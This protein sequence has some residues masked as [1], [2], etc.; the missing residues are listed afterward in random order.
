[1]VKRIAFW[2]LLILVCVVSTGI[3]PETGKDVEGQ[4]QELIDA[5]IEKTEYVYDYILWFE[6]DELCFTEKGYRKKHYRWTYIGKT[7][8]IIL[9]L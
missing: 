5:F 8:C 9:F 4:K 3:I 7:A 6:G 1:M 2:A